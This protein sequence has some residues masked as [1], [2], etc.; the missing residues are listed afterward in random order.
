[1]PLVDR[2][3]VLESMGSCSICGSSDQAP[4]HTPMS[5]PGDDPQIGEIHGI[6]ASVFAPV[7]REVFGSELAD[8]GRQQPR[9][10]VLSSLELIDKLQVYLMATFTGRSGEPGY[11]TLP[12]LLRHFVLQVAPLVSKHVQP[13]DI[14]SCTKRVQ[15]H[16]EQCRTRKYC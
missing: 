11:E 8:A 5:S 15:A 13:Q 4:K 7:I 10:A 3:A 6:L 9:P 14:P 2:L 16:F 12:R 1:M